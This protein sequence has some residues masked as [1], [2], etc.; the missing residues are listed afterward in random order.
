M[1][2]DPAADFAALL[3][4][5]LRRTLDAAD[6]ALADVT[7]FGALV[8]DSADPAADF[9]ALLALGF[10]KTFEA[11]EAAFFPVTSFFAILILLLEG[12]FDCLL[13]KINQVN[14]VM[15]YHTPLPVKYNGI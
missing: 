7:F 1:S 14:I 11:A 10:L 2:A 15:I 13:E 6:P 9:A 5:L 3:A 8:W 12:Y 4:P